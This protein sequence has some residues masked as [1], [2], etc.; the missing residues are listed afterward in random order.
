MPRP[1]KTMDS[2]LKSLKYCETDIVE[3]IRQIRE[4]ISKKFK[5]LQLFKKRDKKEMTTK[6]VTYYRSYIGT[7]ILHFFKKIFKL[8]Y[9]S[10]IW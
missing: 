3:E 5:I 8:N 10:T 9:S 6:Q 4:V 7:I 2:I 1:T